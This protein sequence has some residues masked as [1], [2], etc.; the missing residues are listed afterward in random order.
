[1]KRG[2]RFANWSVVVYTDK[3][4]IEV[5]QTAFPFETYPMLVL[6]IVDWPAFTDSNGLP[7]PEMLRCLR[8]Q[9]AELFPTQI[10]CIR[11]ADTVFQSTLFACYS[12]PEEITEF[13]KALEQW[14]ATFVDTWLGTELIQRP[15]VIGSDIAY[16]KDWH[17]NFPAPVPW[18]TPPFYSAFHRISMF[19]TA[20]SIKDVIRS[21]LGMFAGFVNFASDKSSFPDL[22]TQCVRY[23]GE[24][25]TMVRGGFENEYKR[26][27]SNKHSQ[28]ISGGIVGKDEKILIFVIARLYFDRCFFFPIQYNAENGDKIRPGGYIAQA[29]TKNEHYNHYPGYYISLLEQQNRK[30]QYH[31]VPPIKVCGRLSGML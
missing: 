25:Y 21:P 27:I 15:I 6:C 1:M 29:F 17:S 13:S 4:S 20:N 16:S 5:L 31:V 9:S 18:R 28:G 24:R 14:E 7:S 26:I 22:W 3:A 10:C 30:V 12:K 19:N 11:D 8:F 2:G 23:L